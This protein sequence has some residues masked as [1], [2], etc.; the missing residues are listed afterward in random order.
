MRQRLEARALRLVDER[1]AVEKQAVEEERR[2][3]QLVTEAIDVE[4]PPE[5]RI[6][7][8]KGCGVASGRSAITSPST[9]RSRAGSAAQR[10]DD[11][12]H[13]GGHVAQR[14]RE[15][16]DVVA[17]LVHLNA[18]AIE[19]PL[20]RGVADAAE[21]ILDVVGRI[22]E[23]RLH[24][25]H[26][27]HA[28]ARQTGVALD[29]GGVGDLR[30]LAGHHRGAPDQRRRQARA[31]ARRRRS[32]TPSSAP[33]RSSP[34]SSRTRNDCSSAVTRA[35]RSRKQ[36]RLLDRRPG[37]GRL[38]DALEQ[39]VD[40][41]EIDRGGLGGG[42]DAGAG[43]EAP[44]ETDAPLPQRAGEKRDG[45]GDFVGIEPAEEIGEPA[46][47]VESAA[48]RG[49]G[50]RRLDQVREPHPADP[51]RP[52]VRAKGPHQLGRRADAPQERR[53]P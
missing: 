38:R 6:V 35:N 27:L 15:H 13:G 12:G 16:A 26:Q 21:R 42:D 7:T 30:Q 17:G 46:D 18:R 19:L 44:A 51:T 29:E 39:G 4:P 41:A 2:Q 5:P 45:N 23:H 32:S 20:E 36:R 24:R 33:C 53:A 8:W 3:R 47:L 37:A 52:P 50:V 40:L 34:V 48:D 14:A 43:H 22:G 10:L 49:D 31:R 9:M 28:E 1:R 11:L 25:P